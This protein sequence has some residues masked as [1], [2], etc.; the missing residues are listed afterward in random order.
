MSVAEF[1]SNL[2]TNRL[3]RIA[4]WSLSSLLHASPRVYIKN[5]WPRRVACGTKPLYSLVFEYWSSSDKEL[6]YQLAFFSTNVDPS[7]IRSRTEVSITCYFWGW[8][9]ALNPFQFFRDYFLVD[10]TLVD[11]RCI[12]NAEA[13]LWKDTTDILIFYSSSSGGHPP[14][15]AYIRNFS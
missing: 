7:M 5:T 11:D 14:Q 13:R 1:F 9:K 8:H 10:S 6:R 15:L 2:N 3:I 12:Y 4:H